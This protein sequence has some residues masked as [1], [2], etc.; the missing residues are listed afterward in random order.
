M[1]K[2][3]ENTGRSWL[4]A[5]DS[6]S[7]EVL[8]DTEKDPRAIPPWSAALAETTAPFTENLQ[9]C[10]GKWLLLTPPLRAVLPKAAE[11][12]ALGL[13]LDMV[14]TPTP[15]PDAFR[16][17][18]GTGLRDWYPVDGE[19]VLPM[20]SLT[21]RQ[22][23]MLREH[24]QTLLRGA[25][26]R[27]F[28]DGGIPM[29]TGLVPGRESTEILLMA[30]LYEPFE[31]DN[32]ASAPMLLELCRKLVPL[33]GTLRHSIRF[34]FGMERFGF[35]EYFHR[36]GKGN[37]VF[38]VNVD[39]PCNIATTKHPRFTVYGS[40]ETAPAPQADAVWFALAKEAFGAENVELV[41]GQN[42]GD[43]CC[44][45]PFPGIP[46][47]LLEAADLRYQHVACPQ[48]D[49]VDWDM[50]QTVAQFHYDAI[51]ALDKALE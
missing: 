9:D 41:P 45:K 6:T 8:V 13:L 20:F 47:C 50:M 38:A 46:S 40:S 43:N 48:Y 1:P 49:A 35:A 24:P 11:A 3:W 14:R 18:N 29:V 25:I 36:H 19:P 2:A 32:A 5:S 44:S 22:A 7:S 15:C 10:R 33:A 28:Y 27:R 16:W 23:Q 4:E 21:P 12:G 17:E 34:L 42:T 51:L 37:C 26:A 39:C 31:A 30:H